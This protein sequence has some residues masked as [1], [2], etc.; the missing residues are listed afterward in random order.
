MRSLAWRWKGVAKAVRGVAAR[1]D[2]TGVIQRVGEAHAQRRQLALHHHPERIADEEDVDPGAVT[3][4]GEA[5]VAR[6][7]HRDPVSVGRKFCERGNGEPRDA[8]GGVGAG[9]LPGTH[10]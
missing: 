10:R 1:D 6:S 4:R 2:A 5:R 7:Q 8:G 9:G 3:E